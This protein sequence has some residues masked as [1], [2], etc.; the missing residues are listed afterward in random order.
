MEG[1]RHANAS[2]SVNRPRLREEARGMPK[3]ALVRNGDISAG[4]MNEGF[5]P[6]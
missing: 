2:A 1:D 5:F 4:F 6:A 3:P